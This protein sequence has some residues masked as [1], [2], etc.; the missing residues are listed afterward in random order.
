M[1]ETERLE[2]FK[3]LF[4]GLYL[5]STNLLFAQVFPNRQV[6]SLLQHGIKNII[7]QKYFKA[8]E[9]FTK[10]DKN[11]PELPFGK[12]YLAAC[13]I[14][15]A[16]DYADE[17][18]SEYI[19]SNL[20]KSK[21]I[22]EVL[23]SEDENNIWFN[24]YY[25]LAEGYIAYFDA[26]RE[27]WLSALSTGMNSINY[28]GS[29]L[30][31]DENFYESYIA[32]GTYEYWISRKTEFLEWL[33]FIEDDSKIG[34]E[35]LRTA[36]ESASYNS[37]LATNSL[38]WIYIDQNDFRTAIEL[39]ERA[40]AEFPDSRYF[41]WGLARAYED[42]NPDSSIQLYFE[43]LHSFPGKKNRNYINEI[44]LKHLIAQQ[45]V[46]IGERE[47]ALILCDEILGIR[48]LND[49]ELEKLEN[50]LERVKE[51]KFSLSQ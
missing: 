47:K 37:Y 32:I 46:K 12:I 40:I 49:F 3:I 6:D 18:D 38:I 25:A 13:K 44:I 1:Q 51:L 19:D 11:Y 14:A 4:I 45:Y 7:N 28:F 41:K 43:I 34:I 20:E 33:P 21:E 39:G 29:C 35:K 30:N 15:E 10:L 9:T 26:I 27:N 8:E 16:Y 22:A 2:R 24:Y 23:L 42:V 36:V 50:R 48:N 17:Y 5:F 31:M